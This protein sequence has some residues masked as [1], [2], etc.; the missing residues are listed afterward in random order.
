MAK[1]K[2]GNLCAYRDQTR[3]QK[4]LFCIPSKKSNVEKVEECKLEAKKY[5]HGE[6]Q[7]PQC[8]WGYDNNDAETVGPEK[9]KNWYEKITILFV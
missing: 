6:E 4:G 8:K 7:L 9:W 5:V 3:M 1:Q 2:C